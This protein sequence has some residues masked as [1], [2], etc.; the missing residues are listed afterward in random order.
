MQIFVEWFA[1]RP[2]R[3]GL[4]AMVLSLLLF[5]PVYKTW[6]KICLGLAASTW[7]FLTYTEASTPRNLGARIDLI[8]F[9]RMAIAT[10]IVALIALVFGWKRQF[11]AKLGID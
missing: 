2:Y 10:G 7:W 8:F 6:A 9:S 5:L 1:W 11:A 3:C 4:V